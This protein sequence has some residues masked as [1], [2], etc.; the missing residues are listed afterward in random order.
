MNAVGD[1]RSLQVQSEEGRPLSL[2]GT[3]FARL[4]VLTKD[5]TPTEKA[6]LLVAQKRKAPP[7]S[8]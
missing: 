6:M 4:A 5:Y 1:T 3:R 7:K 2:R 8:P